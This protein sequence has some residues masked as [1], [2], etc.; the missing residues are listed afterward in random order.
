MDQKFLSATGLPPGI[1]EPIIALLSGRARKIFKANAE[2][3]ICNGE[4]AMR[5]EIPYSQNKNLVPFS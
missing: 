5:N 1:L 2:C 3:G 4:F